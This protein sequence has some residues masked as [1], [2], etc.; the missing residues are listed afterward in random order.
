MDTKKEP[1]DSSNLKLLTSS[2]FFFKKM[3]SEKARTSTLE[4]L[5]SSRFI[6]SC[7]QKVQSIKVAAAAGQHFA[8]KKSVQHTLLSLGFAAKIR[9][10]KGQKTDHLAETKEKEEE[11]SAKL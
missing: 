9:Y 1:L 5:R 10:W 8:G 7:C 6:W 11:L 4:L 3:L 2:S